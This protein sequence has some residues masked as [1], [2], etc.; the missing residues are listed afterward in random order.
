M[1]GNHYYYCDYCCYC[2][3]GYYGYFGDDDYYY[4]YYNYFCFGVMEFSILSLHFHCTTR[5]RW[6]GR[7]LAVN[8]IPVFFSFF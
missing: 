1:N 6:K 8:R 3:Y 5:L 4:N 2:Y 7:L